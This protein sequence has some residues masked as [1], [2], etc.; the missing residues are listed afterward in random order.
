MFIFVKMTLVVSIITG[1]TAL[2]VEPT[3]HMLDSFEECEAIQE[4]WRGVEKL[5]LNET[6]YMYGDGY[7]YQLVGSTSY[8]FDVKEITNASN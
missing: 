7:C 4:D 1:Q 8:T 5:Q 2:A 3:Y 6:D